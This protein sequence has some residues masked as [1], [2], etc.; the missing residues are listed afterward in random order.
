MRFCSESECSIEPDV[1][2]PYTHLPPTQAHAGS[3]TKSWRTE[4]SKGKQVC[5]ISKSPYTPLSWAPR[6][7]QFSV[8]RYTCIFFHAYMPSLLP[9]CLHMYTI[10]NHQIGLF[11][12]FLTL[13][14][15]LFLV[16]SVVY[17]KTKPFLNLWKASAVWYG[18][19]VMTCIMSLERPHE[20]TLLFLFHN[21]KRFIALRLISQKGRYSKGKG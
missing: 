18:V 15:Y 13:E 8:F 14:V 2:I 12:I 9:A 16:S 6:H 20:A 10:C 11:H 4:G 1:Y 21:G 7:L 19:H 17:F 3:V 5:S